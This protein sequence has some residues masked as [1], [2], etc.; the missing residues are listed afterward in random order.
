MPKA[1]CDYCEAEL[2]PS[3]EFIYEMESQN[4]VDDEEWLE[5][6][7]RVP[8]YHGEPL[9]ICKQCQ[10]SIDRNDA[11]LQSDVPEEDYEQRGAFRLL[12]FVVILGALG[13]IADMV[14]SFFRNR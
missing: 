4:F 6:I 8:A 1:N 9:R 3:R 13:I 7:R 12:A 14:I 11:D 5:E 2:E 10:A